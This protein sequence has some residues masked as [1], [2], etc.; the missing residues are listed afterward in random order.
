VDAIGSFA[1]YLVR[2]GFIEPAAGGELERDLALWTP[3]V[4]AFCEEGPWWT[5]TGPVATKR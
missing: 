1:S 2:R 3:R 5:R 4:L